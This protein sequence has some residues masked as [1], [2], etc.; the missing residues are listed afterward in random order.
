MEKQI[1]IYKIRVEVRHNNHFY[2]SILIV[3]KTMNYF[4][5]N[6]SFYINRPKDTCLT[7]KKKQW[8]VLWETWGDQ[9][10]DLCLLCWPMNFLSIPYIHSIDATA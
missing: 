3:V 9:G 10:D 1:E 7:I 2:S 4:H 5:T 8:P 6:L